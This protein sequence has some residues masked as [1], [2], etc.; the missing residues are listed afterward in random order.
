LNIINY[1]MLFDTAVEHYVD[2]EEKKQTRKAWMNEWSIRGFSFALKIFQFSIFKWSSYSHLSLCE[3]SMHHR[4]MHI[5]NKK[6]SSYSLLSSWN[7]FSI[8]KA[9][10]FFHS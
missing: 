7:H 9:K 5:D 6:K 1:S 3:F 4:H 8:I 10:K 2:Y